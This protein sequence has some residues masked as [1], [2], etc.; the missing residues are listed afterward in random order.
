MKILTLHNMGT[1]TKRRA[2]VINIETLFKD[3]SNNFLCLNHDAE[4]LLPKF[5]KNINFDLI[6]LGP[7][8]LYSRFNPNTF[9]L[10]QKEYHFI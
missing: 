3:Y 7:T 8:F 1:P 10:F 5:I 9:N 4:I 2:S 6:I